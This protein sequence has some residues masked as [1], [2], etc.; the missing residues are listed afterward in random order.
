MFKARRGKVGDVF[1]PYWIAFR[2]E[3][4]NR[5]C[6]VDRVP[7]D[8]GV[9]EQIETPRLIGLLLLLFATN[10]AFA[11]KEE[12]LAQRMQGFPFIELRV[13]TTTVGLIF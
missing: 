6:H 3:L 1:V 2:A 5:R 11:S 12:E 9:R 4:L 7:G 10:R 8:H 13:D